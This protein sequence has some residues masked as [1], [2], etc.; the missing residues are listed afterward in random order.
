MTEGAP[1]S[2]AAYTIPARALAEWLRLATTLKDADALP[3]RTGDPEAWWPDK[4]Q[5]E[6]DRTQET[7]AACYRC[8]VRA[9]CADYAIAAGEREGAW[10]GCCRPER[11]AM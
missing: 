5:V 3:C 10:G 7:I 8:P 2:N 4:T 6:S 1:G 9:A 11:R